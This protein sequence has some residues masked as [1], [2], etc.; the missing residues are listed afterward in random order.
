MK[1]FINF[2]IALKESIKKDKTLDLCYK[3]LDN[4]ESNGSYNANYYYEHNEIKPNDHCKN[5]T[6]IQIQSITESLNHIL[7]S[8]E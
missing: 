2:D 8:N 7:K 4:L 1:H 5:L 6:T 3:H